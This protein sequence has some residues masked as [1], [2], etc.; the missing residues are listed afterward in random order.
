MMSSSTCVPWIGFPLV[1]VA[2]MKTLSS[3]PK[4]PGVIHVSGH[5]VGGR[6]H[7]EISDQGVGLPEG[8]QV[9]QPRTSLGFKVIVGLLRQLKGSLKIAA[10]EPTG[11]RFR[12]DM[13]LEAGSM[14]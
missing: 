6:L 1:D 7:V 13:P 8:F 4:G 5:A 11:A 2:V 14:Q 12:L 3:Y 10:N 9:D